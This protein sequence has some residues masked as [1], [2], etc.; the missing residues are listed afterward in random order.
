MTNFRN[1][2]T[3]IKALEALKEYFAFAQLA[4]SI[5]NENKFRINITS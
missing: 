3:C 2:L 4:I 5:F 1:S